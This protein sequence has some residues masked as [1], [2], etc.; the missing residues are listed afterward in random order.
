MIASVRASYP[1]A[2]SPIIQTDIGVRNESSAKNWSHFS[3]LF[4]EEGRRKGGGV[5]EE[6]KRR[7]HPLDPPL[8]ERCS[9]CLK[10]RTH[11][12]AL[13][14]PLN[15]FPPFMR[16]RFLPIMRNASYSGGSGS[17]PKHRLNFVLFPFP[18]E[19]AHMNSLFHS[20]P[21]PSFLILQTT[22]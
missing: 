18:P 16:P 7:Q 17:I 20:S 3:V 21:S 14:E 9:G 10:R 1:N 2:I 4:R 8:G 6:Q 5:E 12:L 22:R 11:R 13:F 19:R 15:R